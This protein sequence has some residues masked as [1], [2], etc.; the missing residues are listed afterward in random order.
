MLNWFNRQPR[1]IN[2][3]VYAHTEGISTCPRL[4]TNFYLINQLFYPELVPLDL[5]RPEYILVY[6][7]LASTD[8]PLHITNPHYINSTNT[9]TKWSVP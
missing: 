1:C 6:T 3:R 4:H 5:I 2:Y 7:L 8:K 9:I